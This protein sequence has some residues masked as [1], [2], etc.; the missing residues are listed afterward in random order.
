MTDFEEKERER[1]IIN[2]KKKRQNLSIILPL[3]YISRS[4]ETTDNT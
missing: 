4:T 1:K 2:S 3:Y